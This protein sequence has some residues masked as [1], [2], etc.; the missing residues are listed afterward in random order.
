MKVSVMSGSL[1]PG[2]MSATAWRQAGVR[3]S[4]VRGG[5]LVLQSTLWSVSRPSSRATVR[6]VSWVT[7]AAAAAAAAAGDKLPV[8]G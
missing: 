2:Q 1:G 7:D 5:A 4:D 6:S 8:S 3:R